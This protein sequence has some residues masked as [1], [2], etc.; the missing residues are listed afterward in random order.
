MN[1][2]F[3]ITKY[4]NSLPDPRGSLSSSILS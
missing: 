4:R 2:I 1:E 3:P